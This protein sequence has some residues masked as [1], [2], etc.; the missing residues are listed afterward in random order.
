VESAIY[1]TLTSLCTVAH[2]VQYKVVLSGR[3]LRR[4]EAATVFCPETMFTHASRSCNSGC[5][6]HFR[7]KNKRIQCLSHEVNDL[8]CGTDH[9]DQ[10]EKEEKRIGSDGGNSY[11]YWLQ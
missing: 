1:N 6:I 3:F 4:D 7:K 11:F 9:S 10:R 8:G 5:R 2:I